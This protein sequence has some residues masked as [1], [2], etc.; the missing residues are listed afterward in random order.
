MATIFAFVKLFEKKE[1]AE[2]F[3]NGKLFMNTIKSF[4]E[5]RD[6]SGELRGD[7]HEGIIAMYQ[8]SQLGEITFGEISIPSSELAAPIVVHGDHLL[9]QNVFCIYSLNSRGHE[10]ISAD[11]I[12]EFRTTLELHES[13]FGLGKYCVVVL[14]VTEF[15]N[16]CEVAIETLG[17]EGNLGLVDYFNEHEF[18]GPMPEDK[19]GYQKRSMFREQREYRVK[20]DTQREKPSPYTLEIGDLSDITM[21]TTPAEF[22]E[23]LEIKLPDGTNSTMQSR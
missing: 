9:S 2:D 12:K 10:Y 23:K 14:N 1:H 15:I 18:H 5:Y 11:T 17:L 7:D 8:P 22:N 6:E 16:R 21:L 4:K 13:C 19:L 20:I 3:V